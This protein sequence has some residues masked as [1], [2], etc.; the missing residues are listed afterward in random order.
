MDASASLA[1]AD[2]SSSRLQS[3][4][5]LEEAAAMLMLCQSFSTSLSG[6][7]LSVAE[8]LDC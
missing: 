8:L 5:S 3:D 1:A 7:V 4:V 6:C 2:G